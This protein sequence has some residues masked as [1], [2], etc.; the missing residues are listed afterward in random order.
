VDHHVYVYVLDAELADAQ[1]E[2]GDAR[3]VHRHAFPP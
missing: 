2:L 3:A 1:M